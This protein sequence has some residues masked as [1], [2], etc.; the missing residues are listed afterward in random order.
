[1]PEQLAEIEK[2]TMNE[3]HEESDADNRE[4]AQSWIPLP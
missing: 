4:T 2:P 3:I 1:M